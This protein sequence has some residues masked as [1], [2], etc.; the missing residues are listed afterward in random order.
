M[1]ALIVMTRTAPAVAQ[2]P[3]ALPAAADRESL[4]PAA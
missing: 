4:R 3:K 1:V 2:L